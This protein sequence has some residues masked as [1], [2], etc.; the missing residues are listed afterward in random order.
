MKVDE[1]PNWLG[2][3]IPNLTLRCHLKC[4]ASYALPVSTST[5]TKAAPLK[6]KP[7]GM[8]TAGQLCSYYPNMIDGVNEATMNMC[9]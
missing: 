6:S 1:V 8:S 4:F 2:Q 7:V 9:K 5:S 3:A